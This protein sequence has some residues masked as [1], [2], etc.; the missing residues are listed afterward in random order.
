MTFPA[1]RCHRFYSR[2]S[3]GGRKSL[4]LKYQGKEQGML[5]LFSWLCK[6][7][8]KKI[9]ATAGCEDSQPLTST[10]LKRETF[11]N[12]SHMDGLDVQCI[13]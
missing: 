12:D 4:L 11:E 3:A 2:Y 7:W 1:S 6:V 9:I 10:F 8:T 5:D 13:M